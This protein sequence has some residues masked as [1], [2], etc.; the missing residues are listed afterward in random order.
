MQGE[1]L[2]AIS[3][4]RRASKASGPGITFLFPTNIFTACSFVEYTS[5]HTAREHHQ[6]RKHK[7]D[8]DEYLVSD[9][10]YVWTL[11]ILVVPIS[12]SHSLRF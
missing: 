2:S 6:F 12:D 10:W 8:V 1:Y 5:T 4:F 7:A 9:G 11:G 3:N